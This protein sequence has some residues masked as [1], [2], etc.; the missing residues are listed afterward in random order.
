MEK[1]INV[2]GKNGCLKCKVKHH[3]GDHSPGNTFFITLLLTE[4]YLNLDIELS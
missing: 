2:K 3:F 4:S 1:K